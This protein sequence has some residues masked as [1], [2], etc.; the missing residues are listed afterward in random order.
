MIAFHLNR[1]DRLASTSDEIRRLAETGAPNGTVVLARQQTQGRGRVGRAWSSPAGNLHLSILLRPELPAR[2]IAELGFL[3][4][5]AAAEAVDRAF[6]DGS[7]HATLK[8]PNDVRI[9]GAKIAGILLES[10]LLAEGIAWAAV[11]IGINVAHHPDDTPYPA[12]S[13]HQAGAAS[14]TPDGC[15]AALLDRFGR[16]WEVWSRRGFEPVRAAW[17]ARA[18]QLGQVIGVRVGDRHLSGR[19]DGIGAD[20][21]LLLTTDAG[22]QAITA[23]EVGAAPI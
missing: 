2:R 19:F 18:D 8:W 22:Q 16:W 6:A 20:G 13:L 21:A 11:G 12:T 23:G 7:V 4:G 17:L 9:G 3:A 10:E 15:A 5:L 1:Y 14:A